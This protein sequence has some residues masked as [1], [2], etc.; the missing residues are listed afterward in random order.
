MTQLLTISTFTLLTH[1][2]IVCVLTIRVIMK[3]PATGVALAWILLIA[4]APFLGAAVYLMIGER[5]IGFHRTEGFET[6]RSDYAQIAEAAI[7]RGMTDIDWS[8]CAAESKYMDRLGRRV[9]GFPTVRGSEFQLFHDTQ[10]ILEEIRKDIASAKFSLLIEFYIWQ[11]GGKADEVLEEIIRAA[12]RGVHCCL[13]VDSLG[14]RPWWKTDQPKRLRDAGVQL[15]PALPVG[16]FRTFVGRTDLRLHRK[17]VVV[18]GTVAWTGSMN[19]VDPRYFKQDS[20]VGQWVDAMVRLQGSVV[21]PLAAT[22]IGDWILES[23]KS[24][25]EMIAEAKLKLVEPTGNTDIQ[26][27]PSGPG[28]SSDG[29]LQMILA[30]INSAKEEIV[31][32]TPYL[33]PDDSLLR[34]IRG[35][36]AAGVTVRLIVPEKVDSLLARYA[37]RSYFDDLLASEVEVY[38]YRD[39]LLHT[40]SI[41]VD[42]HTSMFGTVNLDMR[43]LWLNYEV[44]LY[45]YDARFTTEVRALQQTYIENSDQLLSDVWNQRPLAE[46]FLENTFRLTSPLL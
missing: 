41:T 4:V 42:G 12:K 21:V 36:A 2:L 14:A 29:Q 33:V 5:R 26:V 1:Y 19:L 40:K 9:V 22:M 38:R 32:T 23:G 17:I 30:L 27:V 8:L 34:A 15:L 25:S 16:V 46:R 3:R 24:V 18:D 10:E 7:Q 20:G 11:A 6:L 39:G 13:L 43:S 37:S 35:A 44:A 28:M 45:V 31:M